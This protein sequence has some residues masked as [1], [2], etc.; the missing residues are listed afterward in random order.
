MIRAGNKTDGRS[1]LNIK[2]V[3]TEQGVRQGCVMLLLLVNAL[4]KNNKYL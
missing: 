3:S 4:W 1:K 2:Q